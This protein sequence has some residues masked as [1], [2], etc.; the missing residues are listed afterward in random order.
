[1]R[2]NNNFVGKAGLLGALLVAS[3]CVQGQDLEEAT[4]YR[5][6]LN[7]SLATGEHTPF[8]LTTNR[9]GK[10][11]LEANNGYLEA[12]VFHRQTFGDG[13]RW[14]AMLDG[15]AVVPRYRNVYV[16]QCYAGIGYKSLWLEVGSKERTSVFE[17]DELS[18]GDVILSTNARPIPGMRLAMPSFTVVPATKGWLQV[19]G[20]FSVSRS[21]DNAYLAD[22]T[23]QSSYPYVKDVLW[24]SKSFY[25]QVRDTRGT[26]PLS[27]VIGF[28]HIAQWG[29]TSTDPELGRQ[30]RSFKD[31][32]RVVAGQKGG[33]DAS[34]SD[35]IN[36]LGNHHISYDLRLRYTQNGWDLTAYHQHLCSDKSGME[37]YNGTDGLWGLE[38]T[39]PNTLTFHWV[40]KLLVEHFTTMNGSGPFHYIRFDHDK[41]PGRGGGGDDYYNNGAYRNGNSY[42]NRGVGSPLVPAPEYN[43]DGR[44]G[45]RSSRVHDWHFG[46]AGD[47]SPYMGYRFLFTAMQSYGTAMLPFIDVKK[48]TSLLIDLVYTHPRLSGWSF[49]GSLG[50]DTGNVV[51]NGIGFSFSISKQGVFKR[52]KSSSTIKK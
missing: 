1:M 31:F 49:N 29:G 43:E 47:V 46:M 14:E 9:Y 2:R 19:K 52:W 32:L 12:A 7:A 18:T 25:V 17:L 15:V 20:D 10:T 24:H 4:G 36:V 34:L 5:V 51:G 39:F 50:W 37:F 16:Q 22:F 45:F 28:Q 44:L 33:E 27:G 6:G 21:F 35:Q 8:W 11:P 48:G 41:Y 38:L 40:K 3:V 42:F 26:F 13:F 30:P 23:Q